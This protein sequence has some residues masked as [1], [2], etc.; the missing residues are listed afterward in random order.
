MCVGSGQIKR[1][2]R[3]SDHCRLGVFCCFEKS[4][5]AA[6]I[7]PNR[8]QMEDAVM[9]SGLLAYFPLVRSPLGLR[10]LGLA[11]IVSAAGEALDSRILSLMLYSY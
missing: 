9:A 8:K 5:V 4:F 6:A 1:L 3:T 7:E 2:S 11:A 10:C